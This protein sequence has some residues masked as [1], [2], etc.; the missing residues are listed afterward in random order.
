M[1]DSNADS[2]VLNGWMF[3][4]IFYG[5]EYIGIQQQGRGRELTVVRRET[6]TIAWARRL[7][8]TDSCGIMRFHKH[9]SSTTMQFHKLAL[10]F[11]LSCEA[12]ASS[13]V[14]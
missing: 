10:S 3:R 7:G 8:T 5:A 2:A 12:A 4:N 14:K 13:C 11:A 6:V 1:L 9:D